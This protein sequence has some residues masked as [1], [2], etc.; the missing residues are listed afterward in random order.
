MP[1]GDNCLEDGRCKHRCGAFGVSSQGSV[2]KD[3][4]WLRLQKRIER[5]R[6]LCLCVGS[7]E[8]EL[9]S[10]TDFMRQYT[11][12][13]T[14]RVGGRDFFWRCSSS[15]ASRS[16]SWALFCSRSRCRRSRFCGGTRGG[17]LSGVR[18]GQA[19]HNTQKKTWPK[20]FRSSPFLKRRF[21]KR[22]CNLQKG[23]DE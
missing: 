9:R 18:N 7:T 1:R 13:T 2:E 12:I 21:S 5:V 4:A 8:I 15:A 3:R 11:P 6:R 19:S 20:F 10:E 14:L 23:P 16:A 22:M 17:V